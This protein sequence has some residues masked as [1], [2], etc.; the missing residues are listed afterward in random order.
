MKPSLH[1]YQLFQNISFYM[2]ISLFLFISFFLMISCQAQKHSFEKI[3]PEDI[4][5]GAER[6]EDYLLLL[7]GKNVGIVGN[8]TSMIGDVHL[9][10]SLINRNVNVVRVFSPEHGFRGNRE[11]GASIKNGLD[12]RTGLPVISLYGRH[13]KPTREDLQDIDIM[14]F[15]IQDVGTRFY[16]Y[17][18]TMTYVM[19]ACAENNIPVIVL[20]RPNP[21]GHYVD[22]PVLDTAFSSF[23]GMHPVPV[24]HGMTIGEYA[25]MVNG[26]GWLKDGVQCDLSVIPVE[27]YDH[28]KLY[29]LP[30]KPSPNLPVMNAVYLYPS[31]CF[32]EGT[33]VS[34]G[35]GTDFPFEVYGH[36]EF[37]I[38]SFIF[39]PRRI[40]GVSLKPKH[41][42]QE[43]FGA[44]L[45]NYTN[46]AGIPNTINLH[47]LIGMYDFFKDKEEFFIPYFDKLAGND[48]LR[49]QIVDGLSEAEIN[50]SWQDD[51]EKFK[52]IRKKYLIYPD[53]E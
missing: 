2:R 38:G 24:V 50:K 4:K 32:F 11:A 48:L 43:C 42:D 35:R 10:D 33:L 6:T 3:H 30:V 20:D 18:S 15:D 44:S 9:V 26:E 49:K 46:T 5:T 12:T 22:G 25:K 40:P 36:P 28:G 34:I 7:Q 17:I 47:W 23:V 53:F 45:Q 41:K 27:N 21:N 51:L 1:K 13:K 52:T 8:H 19:E 31:L 29:Q 14:L 39:T 37:K 16:T